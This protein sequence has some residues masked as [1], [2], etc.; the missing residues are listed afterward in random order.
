MA[1]PGIDKKEVFRA[2]D[3]LEVEGGAVTVTTVR[4]RLGNKGSYTTVSTALKEWRSRQE[5]KK[6]DDAP[7][8]PDV[9]SRLLARVWAEA[10]NIARQSFEKEKEAFTQ[11]QR[12]IE[13][14]REEMS[15]EIGRLETELLQDKKDL[16]AAHTA[17][18][19]CAGQLEQSKIETVRL[20]EQVRALEE[21]TQSL[22]T[23]LDEERGRSE[24]LEETLVDLAR[25]DHSKSRP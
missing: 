11:A 17:R 23:R 21:S 4:Q 24:R 1:R 19:Q 3:E 5:E 25:G 15:A 8:L 10:W 6:G 7:P 18:Q 13:Q 2:A 12:Q 20:T 22:K 16:A 9:L 14:D